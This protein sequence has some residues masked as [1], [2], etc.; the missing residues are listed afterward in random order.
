MRNSNP[1]IRK[2]LYKST[3]IINE[4]STIRKITEADFANDDMPED[5]I[6]LSDT[7]TDSNT[8]PVNNQETQPVPQDN[9][10]P[11]S[12]PVPNPVNNTQ[13]NQPTSN[14]SVDSLQNDL[15]KMNLSAMIKIHGELDKLNQTV[16][17][18]N[19]QNQK[20]KAQVEEVREP[21]NEEK[22][23]ARKNDSFPY[24]NNLNDIWKDNWFERNTVS[25]ENE[26][27]TKLPDGSYIAN[28][29]DLPK[30][31]DIKKSF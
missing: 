12:Q 29:D 19:Q 26:G 23:L 25:S 14:G 7:L 8:E 6:P 13:L 2:I 10:E 18:L 9:A 20:L 1:H 5:V 30:Y 27:I 16:N 22:L 17:D 31:T 11:A 28:F 15:I 21:S 24:Y 4:A 3:Y